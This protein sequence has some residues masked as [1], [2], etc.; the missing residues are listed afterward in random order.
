MDKYELTEGEGRTKVDL[1]AY[2][3]G[4]HPIVCIYNENAHIGAVAVGEYDHNEKRAS[5]SVITRLGHKDDV[6]ALKAAYSISKRTK[7][8]V[9]VIAGIH[10]DNITREEIGETVENAS[11]LVE[12]FIESIAQRPES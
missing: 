9:C 5:T 2:H 11:I 7:G 10:L 1:L 3:M 6:V 8:P 4:N 12:K